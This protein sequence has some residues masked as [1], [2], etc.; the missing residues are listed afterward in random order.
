MS[1]LTATD[2]INNIF[3]G[4]PVD[5][6]VLSGEPVPFGTV[7]VEMWIEAIKRI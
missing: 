3:A 7:P 1:R 2:R 6:P 5:L 4:A